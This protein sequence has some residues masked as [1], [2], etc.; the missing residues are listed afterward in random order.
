MPYHPYIGTFGSSTTRTFLQYSH[1][2]GKNN[3]NTSLLF[4][5]RPQSGFTSYPNNTL[6]GQT[7]Q[8][9]ILLCS[10]FF[11][12]LPHVPQSFSDCHASPLLRSTGNWFCKNA[13]STRSCLMFHRDQIQVDVFGRNITKERLCSW[14]APLVAGLRAK[15][16]ETADPLL[17]N[18]R[19][20]KMATAEHETPC[21]AHTHMALAPWAFSTL[22]LISVR[23]PRVQLRPSLMALTLSTPLAFRY[24][25]KCFPSCNITRQPNFSTIKFTFRPWSGVRVEGKIQLPRVNVSSGFSIL[26]SGL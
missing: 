19:N 13:Q 4:N 20:F 10:Y 15:C 6:Y 9:S 17:K 16:N 2:D 26:F 14:P 12:L 18:F 1:Q 21:A 7:T 3:N 11:S 8:D 23:Q 5:L 24:S 25:P 22:H